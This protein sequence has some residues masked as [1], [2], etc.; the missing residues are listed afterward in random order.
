MTT[1]LHPSR[2]SRVDVGEASVAYRDVVAGP[3]VVLRHSGHLLI[4]ERPGA[5]ADLVGRFLTAP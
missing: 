5:Y 2:P 1:S 3:T 4:E